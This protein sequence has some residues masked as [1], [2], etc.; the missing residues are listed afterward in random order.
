M[1]LCSPFFCICNMSSLSFDD[2]ETYHVCGAIG[3]LLDDLPHITHANVKP[4]IIAVL[5]HRGAVTFNEIVSSISLHC[6]LDDLRMSDESDKSNLELIVEEVL[7]EMVSCKVLRYNEDK[8]FWVISPG[9]NNQNV[10]TVIS[11]ASNLGAQIPHHFTL[12]MSPKTAPSKILHGNPAKRIGSKQ[13]SPGKRSN[14]LTKT[15]MTQSSTEIAEICDQIKNLLLQKNLNYGDSALNPS[16]VFSKASPKEQLLVRID[17]KL[18][19]ISKGAGLIGADEDVIQDLIG[20]LV[21]LQISLRREQIS[22]PESFQSAN[23]WGER[24]P[25]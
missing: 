19:R 4:Y 18:S 2:C 5:L 1:G 12:E 13:R 8:D 14:T 22:E 24:C 20:Y 6:P 25:D 3:T 21:L 16:R 7:G 9:T 15:A 17:D 11:W 23:A 10:P